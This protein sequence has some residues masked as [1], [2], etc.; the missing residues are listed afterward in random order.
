MHYCSVKMW[1]RVL[2]LAPNVKNSTAV[3]SGYNSRHVMRCG[4]L[5]IMSCRR[6]STATKKRSRAPNRLLLLPPHACV[7]W[8]PVR[9]FSLSF[10]FCGES[11]T[12]I[13]AQ[14][15]ARV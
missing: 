7:L 15:R 3:G 13:G 12:A 5:R 8:L 4:G 9:R 11:A 1:N 14:R 10:P 2:P 6:A